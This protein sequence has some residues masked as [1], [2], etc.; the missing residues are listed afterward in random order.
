MW[1]EWALKVLLHV[2]D[3]R[4]SMSVTHI[5]FSVSPLRFFLSQCGTT[6]VMSTLEMWKEKVEHYI[7]EKSIP[8]SLGIVLRQLEYK[9][10]K[11]I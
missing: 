10:R 2:I 11:S 8:N 9:E 3:I 4:H 7:F 6:N 1:Y 5:L